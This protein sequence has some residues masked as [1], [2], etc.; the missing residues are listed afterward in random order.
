M[1]TIGIFSKNFFKMLFIL[2]FVVSCSG[3]SAVPVNITEVDGASDVQKAAFV[4]EG[5]SC[6]KACVSSVNKTITAINGVQDV[7]IGFDADRTLD[8]C[9]VSY[10]SSQVGYQEMLNAINTCN[11]GV[12]EVKAVEI[13]KS[14]DSELNAT[15]SNSKENQ[16]LKQEKMKHVEFNFPSFTELFK[17]VRFW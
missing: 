3:D 1:S 13:E 14:K 2:M 8:T 15:S 5:M 12:Y 17:S 7:N 9:Y 11:G 10:N 16:S 4:I 6:E